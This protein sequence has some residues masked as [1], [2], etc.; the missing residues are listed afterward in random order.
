MDWIS[1]GNIEIKEK[2]E[3]TNETHLKMVDVEP[4]FAK[5]GARDMAFSWKESKVTELFGF[6]FSHFF[7]DVLNV[8]KF[9]KR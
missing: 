7:F 2:D 4:P 3:V 9:R 5:R 8:S 1:K 6:L